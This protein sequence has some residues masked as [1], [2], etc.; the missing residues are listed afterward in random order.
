PLCAD[1]GQFTFYDQ[2]L[3]PCTMSLMGIDQGSTVKLKLAVAT[4]F[5]P[6]DLDFSTTPVLGLRLTATLLGG[7]FRWAECTAVDEV[8]IFLEIAGDGL[9]VDASGADAVDLRFSSKQGGNA[10]PEHD[11]LVVL[12]GER[13]GVRFT[14]KVTLYDGAE[15]PLDVAWCTHSA[16]VLEIQ[17]TK[18]PFKYTGAYPDLDAVCAWARQHPTAIWDNAAAVDGIITDNTFSQSINHLL[19]QTL[20]SWLADTW[21][22]NRNGSDWFSVWEGSCYFHSTVDVEYTQAPFYLAVWPELLRSELDFWPEYSKDGARTLGERGAGT[23]FLSHDT[24]Q[25]VSANGQIY[26]HDMEVEETTN[27]LILS[28]AYY[29][30]T[31]DVTVA[32]KHADILEQYLAFLAACDTTG[33]G[34]PDKGVANTIDDASPAVQFGD[35]Q[36]YLAVKTLAAF[37]TGAELLELVGKPATAK[38]YRALADKVRAHIEK[39]GWQGDHYATLLK[40]N[41]RIYDAWKDE[42][43]ELAEVPGWDAAHIYT[44]N[45]LA[46]LDMIGYDLGLNEDHLK[47]DL[48][49]ATQR[50]LREYG[51]VHSDYEPEKLPEPIPG[52]TGAAFSPGWVSMNML[53]DIAAFYRGVDLRH[54]ADRYWEWQTTTNTQEPKLFF[55]T[56][57]GNNLCFYPRGIAIWGY[58]DAL[59]GRVIDVVAGVDRESKPF[60]GMV[61]PRLLDV[62]WTALKV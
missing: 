26:Q 7:N 27:Y 13:H 29:K 47:T 23:L 21:C 53:R 24:G 18:Y 30:R 1:G 59:A 15:Q 55:E 37:A 41:G 39:A 51:C 9:Q 49:V 35:E 61:A 3:S 52:L 6:R 19:A 25:H 42:T 28:Y 56:F 58:F 5:R 40:P 11:R 20:H 38:T 43:T 62:E 54:L 46:L 10:A 2:R 60:N 17:G 57:N 8:E 33:N 22:V 34:I 44:V 45:G 50:C 48:Q 31:G 14:R 36:V 4:P 32:R 12:Q 16:P